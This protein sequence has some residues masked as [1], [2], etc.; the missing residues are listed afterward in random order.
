MLIHNRLVFL[1]IALSTLLMMPGIRVIPLA[2]SGTLGGE[3]C[4]L[5]ILGMIGPEGVVHGTTQI[6]MIKGL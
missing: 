4:R 5:L 3:I 1:P 2:S 6:D